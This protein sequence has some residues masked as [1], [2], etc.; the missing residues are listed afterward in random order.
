MAMVRILA[1]L[2]LVAACGGKTGNYQQDLAG[3]IVVELV[4]QSP[5]AIERLHIYPH[6]RVDRGPSWA[7]IEPG[8]STTVRLRAGVFELH[9]VSAKRQIDEQ[10]REVAEASTMLELRTDRPSLK[11][12]FHDRHAPP[13]GLGARHVLGV[14]FHITTARPSADEAAG[15]PGDPPA[16]EGDAAPTP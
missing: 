11:I 9:A 2:G 7:S 12:V 1:V 3:P 15:D 16:P 6:G 5:R 13:P 4:N 8:A 14:A 10:T